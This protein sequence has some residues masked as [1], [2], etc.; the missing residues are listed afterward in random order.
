MAEALKHTCPVCQSPLRETKSD[1]DE[2]E[3]NVIASFPHFIARPFRSLHQEQ[4]IFEKTLSLV[5]VFTNMLKYMA[6]IVESEYLQSELK[7]DEELNE[8]IGQDLCRPLV[9][10]W[11]KFM[12]AAIPKLEEAGHQFFIPELPGFWKE[13][14]KQSI[15]IP[16]KGYYEEDGD[17]V[18]TKSKLT[19][20]QALVSYRNKFAHR[21]KQQEGAALKEFLFYYDNAL[22]PIMEKML[23]VVQ[24][25]IIKRE[26][27]AYFEMMG[28]DIQKLKTMDAPKGLKST[29][30]VYA[31]ERNESL[32][33]APFFIVPNEY[34]TDTGDD[35]DILIYDQNT[36]KRLCYVSP[37]GHHR[38]TDKALVEWRKLV[39]SKRI[40]APLLSANEINPDTLR[41]RVARVSSETQRGLEESKKVIPGTHCSR[42]IGTSLAL[43]PES[44]SSLC[45]VSAPVGA[46]KTCFLNELAEKW[47]EQGTSVL[48]LRAAQL[49]SSDLFAE[50]KSRLRV[51]PSVDISS[52]VNKCGTK[53]QPLVILLDGV[54]GHAGRE[55]LL[56]SILRLGR[57]SF[58]Q[59]GLRTL[60]SLRPGGSDWMSVDA[61][62]AER[63]FFPAEQGEK[64]NVGGIPTTSLPPLSHREIE[65]MWS[66]YSNA[67]GELFAPKFDYQELTSQSRRV[68]SLLSNPQIL[69]IFLRTFSGEK[70]PRELDRYGIF[71]AFFE[72]LAARSGDRGR[73]L[74]QLAEISWE[75]SSPRFDYDDLIQDERTSEDLQRTD[76]ASPYH[77]LSRQEGVLSEEPS[78]DGRQVVFTA[79]LL[80]EH[81]LGQYLVESGQADTSKEL[82]EV[83][84]KNASH[85]LLVG[86]IQSAL[87]AKLSTDGDGFLWEFIEE[88]S[89]R[90][91]T[92]A[93]ELLGKILREGEDLG[94]IT[95][96]LMQLPSVNDLHAGLAASALLEEEFAFEVRKEFLEKLSNRVE[97]I[98]FP[99]SEILGDLFGAV[100]SA[101]YDLG[102]YESCRRWSQRSLDIR[103]GC[104]GN[105]HPSVATSWNNLG[106]LHRKMGDLESAGPCYLEA[107]ALFKNLYGEKHAS[108]ATLN[109]NLGTLSRKLGKLEDARTYCEKA[110]E[111]RQGIHGEEHPATA[112]CL[113]NLA[114]LHADL[115]EF[116]AAKDLYERALSVRQEILGNHHPDVA[117]SHNNLGL[118]ERRWGNIESARAHYEKSLSIFRKLWGD[119]HP[120]IASGLNNLGGLHASSGNIDKARICYEEA[121][122]IFLEVYGE[123]HP[124]VAT[125]CNNLGNLL[126][127][128]EETELAKDFHERALQVRR[129]T[130]G[131]N[132]PQTASSW[133]SLGGVCARIGEEEKA[134]ECFSKALKIRRKHFDDPHP[135]V[136]AGYSSLGLL[137]RKLGNLEEARECFVRA[138]EI[139]R[140]IYGEVHTHVATAHYNLAGLFH[141]QGEREEALQHLESALSVRRKLLGDSHRS[142]GQT[143][144]SLSRVH[145][146]LGNF[147]K[148]TECKEMAASIL[149]A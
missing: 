62:E 122:E 21:A 59:P 38:E 77:R 71:E 99:D 15:N 141:K 142:V 124:H 110:L 41:E 44:S 19:L 96:G 24:Y 128:A 51:N 134:Q 22:R 26:G 108:I 119:S 94:L 111:I 143:W 63:L 5:D 17:F 70:L 27:R 145:K 31:K 54:G 18:Q 149:K 53:E 104:L 137:E 76:I 57:A 14:E 147:E 3:E 87:S 25:P 79:D 101:T 75:T 43:F 115:G 88:G 84:E 78:D 23:W 32:P 91:A 95:E 144:K 100:A 28:A 81:V 6:L 55:E 66:K 139:F 82:L 74:R 114:S 1:L 80:L 48:F 33:L 64:R 127:G 4:N 16:G 52:F 138:L 40:I 39:E 90:A 10:S 131:D 56:R 36:G 9:S 72:N 121:L 35:E 109:G 102:D 106:N 140:E 133:H 116:A 47:I 117:A 46:G 34:L 20:F 85:P 65:T 125:S 123:N 146:A 69:R 83:F 92:C 113:N 7:G 13:I 136:A 97:E 132:H 60:F 61:E 89:P 98:G 49:D 148:A 93:G 86:A 129:R 107:L 45:A 42:N 8:I 73:F 126:A 30:V 105:D 135:Q 37:C 2:F 12:S 68:L 118:V 50:V 11:R 58:G 67:G 112:T 130:F 103:R 29:L 120:T